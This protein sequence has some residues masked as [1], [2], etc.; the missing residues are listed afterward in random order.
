MDL[1]QPKQ[2]FLARDTETEEPLVIYIFSN[3]YWLAPKGVSISAVDCCGAV[4]PVPELL[5]GAYQHFK[6]GLYV[7]FNAGLLVGDLLPYAIY[8]PCGDLTY[9]A[10]PLAMFQESVPSPNGGAM[11]PRFVSLIKPRS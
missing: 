1:N 3:A 4:G 9:W 6:G 10:R 11:V 2:L 8:H 5:P 7:V